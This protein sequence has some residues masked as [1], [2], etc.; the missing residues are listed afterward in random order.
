MG[1][2]M[3]RNPRD[4]RRSKTIE[5]KMSPR[6]MVEVFGAKVHKIW[7][8]DASIMLSGFFHSLEITFFSFSNSLWRE[9]FHKGC[10]FS[11]VPPSKMHQ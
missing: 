11:K 6:N 4:S 10:W 1:F 3:E 5:T 2:S 9:A 8:F 7:C